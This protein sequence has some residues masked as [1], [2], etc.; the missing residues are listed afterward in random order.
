MLALLDALKSSAEEFAAR[1]EKL[2]RDFQTR[3]TAELTAFE[4][5]R[6]KE[7]T[8]WSARIADAEATLES[9]KTRVQ[10]RFEKRKA[11]LNQAHHIVRKAVMESVSHDEGRRKYKIQESSLEAERRKQAGL[12]NAVTT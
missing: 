12:A 8:E 1:E 7:E 5:A 10:V 2:N 4:A 11:R 9:A 6:Q 3:S